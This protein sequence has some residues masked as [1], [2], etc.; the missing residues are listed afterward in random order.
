[1]STQRRFSKNQVCRIRHSVN[2]LNESASSVAQQYSVSPSTIRRIASGQSYSDI[3]M[4]RSV[5]GFPSYLA[6]PDN[7]I[8]STS[9]NKFLKSVQ[10]GNGT[11]YNL[12]NGQNRQAIP[13]RGFEQRIFS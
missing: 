9:R 7:R 4:A 11:Y 12:W 5:P 10:K 2:I 1:M 3:P 8:W 13:R 6:Y